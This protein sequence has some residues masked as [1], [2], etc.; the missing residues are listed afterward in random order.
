MSPVSP[1]QLYLQVLAALHQILHVI[2][3]G[4]EQVE[5]LEE[6]VFLLWEPCVRQEFYQVAKVVA[7]VSKRISDLSSCRFHK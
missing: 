7:T 2:D 5:D 1:S 6:L 3:G 4:K